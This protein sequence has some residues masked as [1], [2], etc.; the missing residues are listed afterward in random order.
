[1][2]SE[3]PEGGGMSEDQQRYLRRVLAGGLV[4]WVAAATAELM[5]GRSLST[6]GLFC[7][8]VALGLGAAAMAYGFFQLFAG[9]I[10]QWTT[11]PVVMRQLYARIVRAASVGLALFAIVAP[12]VP[13]LKRVGAL[14]I[15]GLAP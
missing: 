4:L 8:R 7:L 12:L 14:P 3:N 11:L 15:K 2:T 13:L 1:M 5:F 6:A 10:E 9:R